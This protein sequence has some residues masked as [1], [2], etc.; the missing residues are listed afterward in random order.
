MK[1][2]KVTTTLLRAPGFRSIQ[3]ATMPPPRSAEGAR[4]SLFVH[5]HTDAGV[6]GLGFAASASA[7]RAVIEDSLKDLL[8]GEDPFDIER[9]WENM[10]WRVRG[11]GRK[12]I[13]FCGISALD[14]ALWDLKAKALGVPLFKLL[15]PYRD[16]VPVYGSGGWTNFDEKEL[17]EEQTG[18]VER[19][20]RSVK[21]KVGKDFGKAEREDVR[22]L[23]AVRKAV[24]DDVEVL[25]DANNGYYAK[26]A[27]GM[28]KEF[29]PFR[30]GWFEEPVLAD[31]IEGLAAVAR[32][33]TIPVATGEHE[34]TKF[35]FKDLIARAGADIVQ[36]DLGRVGGVT[37]WLKVAHL[38][39]AFNLPV[40]PH[41]YALPSLHL[42]CATPNLRIVEYLGIEEQGYITF[43]AEYPEPKDGT[44]A[45]FPDRPGFGVELNPHAVEKYRV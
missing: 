44:W 29:E 42:A 28:A 33:T 7:V 25:I 41:A 26:Q 21:M 37:E 19:G 38:A 1:I 9:H 4:T 24:G 8:I 22:R 5:I 18:Y 16:R 36:P 15:G 23:A 35:G 3:D 34:Y 31:D 45:P 30:V 43:L 2:T 17:L 32:A 12:G 20:F 14:C 10:F 39:H 40:A 6:E 13:A 11:F 27:I